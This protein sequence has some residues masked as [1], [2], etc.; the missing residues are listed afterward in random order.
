MLLGNRFKCR[1]CC[2]R[3]AT[4]SA[5]QAALVEFLLCSSAA[6]IFSFYFKKVALFIYF[7]KIKINKFYVSRGRLQIN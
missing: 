6:M 5:F 4:C 2:K 3:S 1:G 7:L